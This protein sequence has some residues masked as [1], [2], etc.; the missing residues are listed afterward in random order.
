ME[1]M[2]VVWPQIDKAEPI[3]GWHN[4]MICE[5]LEAVSAGEIRDLIISIPPGMGKTSAVS[6]AWP[7]W[8]WLEVNASLKYI[9]A[10]YGEKLILRDS[11]KVKKLFETKWFKDRWP[12][13]ELDNLAIGQ[14]EN[15]EKGVRFATSVG[16]SATGM[17]GDR[18]IVDDPMKAADAIGSRSALGTA[19]GNVSDWWDTTMSTR[20]TNPKTTARVVVAQRLH[21]LDLSGHIMETTDNVH[22]LRLP[23]EFEP[24][25]R[26]FM[27]WDSDR[28]V[29]NDNGSRDTVKWSDKTGEAPS[30]V[31]LVD[32]REEHGELL[33]PERYDEEAVKRLKKR[34]VPKGGAA[35]FT[36]RPTT[37]GGG[38]YKSSSFLRWGMPNSL[39]V[40]IP[41][42]CQMIQTWDLAFGSH[43]EGTKGSFTV[44]QVWARVGA[45]F[46]L[47]DQERGNWELPE[48]QAAVKR[49]TARWPKAH[50][51]YIESA[52]AAKSLHSTM[53]RVISG[54]HLVPAGGGTVPRAHAAAIYFSSGNVYFPH[55]SFAPWI[56]GVEEELL[57]FPNAKNDDRLDCVTYGVTLL[58]DSAA[59]GYGDAMK[60]VRAGA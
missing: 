31:S 21:R 4:E 39:Y 59:A 29:A 57:D 33:C 48:M 8:E 55:K 14:L 16:G 2:R 44:G 40:K 6:V 54:L 9:M 24:K 49:L 46:L 53:R 10:G 19:L 20:Q 52:A 45:D 43:A 34:L 26:C 37:D 41:R 5:A 30:K 23:M 25:F 50:K 32:P 1:F 7:V 28:S 11:G 42:R 58:A 47:L 18:I 38:L 3:F 17:H 35:Q 12:D 51:K 22:E 27:G 60:A 36:Q 13:L 15:S 56:E